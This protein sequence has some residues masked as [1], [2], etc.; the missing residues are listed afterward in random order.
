MRPVPVVF[1][2][3]ALT[4][5]LYFLRRA[6]GYAQA[7]HNYIVTHQQECVTNPHINFSNGDVSFLHKLIVIL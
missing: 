4:L 2:L 7:E 3:S 5:Q 1:L 6:A